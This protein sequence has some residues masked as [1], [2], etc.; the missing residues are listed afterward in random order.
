VQ[1]GNKKTRGV[2]FQPQD[3]EACMPFLDTSRC[4]RLPGGQRLDNWHVNNG[5]NDKV[6]KRHCHESHAEP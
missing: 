6:A 5:S 1:Q 4:A 2:V 3:D